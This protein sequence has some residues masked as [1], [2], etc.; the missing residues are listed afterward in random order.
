MNKEK[1]LFH[2]ME[3]IIRSINYD[4]NNLKRIYCV[5]IY[6]CEFIL[7]SQKNNLYKKL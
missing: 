1:K 3:M 6:F 2:Y 5:I 4:D 7:E